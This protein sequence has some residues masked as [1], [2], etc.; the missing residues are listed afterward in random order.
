MTDI[1]THILPRMDDGSRSVEESL[2]ML[3]AS[4]AQGIPQ[5]LATPHFYP[6]EEGPEAFL[7]RRAAAAARLRT[8]L[9]PGLPEVRLG[10]EVCYF[11]GMARSGVLDALRLEGT[12]ALLL[13]M[14]LAP[15]TERMLREVRS[16]QELPGT[17]VLAHIERYLG[18]QEPRVWDGLLEL[19]IRFQCNASFFLHW[20]TRRRAL[21]LLRAG[22]VH[23]LGSDCHG[24]DRRPPRLGEAL[25]LLR[26][27]ERRMLEKNLAGLA[28]GGQEVG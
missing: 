25:A 17:V 18:L 9:R 4:G 20:R 21:K 6:A 12:G 27:E 2:A 16:V 5:V 28:S 13:E 8:V 1:H 14:P 7:A 15:W 3:E 19:G 10:A 23:L 11:E 22:R 24:V 26:P